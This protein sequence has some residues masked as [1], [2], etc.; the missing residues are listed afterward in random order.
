MFLP[1]EHC[2]HHEPVWLRHW[3]CSST[4]VQARCKLRH[5]LLLRVEFPT[6]H[7]LWKRC[8]NI[9]KDLKIIGMHK[10]HIR[11]LT[12]NIIIYCD[13]HSLDDFGF[14]PVTSTK[15]ADLIGFI[16]GHIQFSGY[17]RDKATV[18]CILIRGLAAPCRWSDLEYT[19]PSS[20]LVIRVAST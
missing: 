13:G 9:S 2:A 18:S 19:L 17:A 8:R 4:S 10:Q 5:A 6:L 14:Q 15:V 12:F 20:A 16:A 3:G 1:N 11:S 7:L